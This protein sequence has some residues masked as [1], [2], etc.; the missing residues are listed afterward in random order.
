M[1]RRI[2]LAALTCIELA[3]PE[4]V[5]AAAAAGYDCV[6]FRLIGVAGQALPPFRLS[7]LEQRLADT[8]LEVLDVEIFRL[9]AGTNILAFEPTL[10]LAQRLGATEVL[11]HGADP[12]E[13][14]LVESFSRLCDLAALHGLAANLEPMPW[15]DVSTV[16]KARR[17]IEKSGRKNAA[18]LVDAIHFYR[19]DNCLDDLKGSPLR[20]LQFCDAHPGRPAEMQ[21]VIRQARGDRLLPGD[22]ALDLR[23]LL[24]A[25]P[26]DLPLSLEIPLARRMDPFERA[27][28]ALVKTRAFLEKLLA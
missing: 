17:V 7:E 15:V 10:A 24:R 19:A 22:G 23:S 21:E 11:V 12:D 16:R 9:D 14:R 8:G 25:L 2:G 5:S 20:Y 28:Q 4:L 27:A 1:K 6:G 13:A 26:P 3:P 18:V